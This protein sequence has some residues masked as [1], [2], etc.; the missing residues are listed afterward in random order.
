MG[1]VDM[2]RQRPNVFRMRLLGAEVVPV[3][4]GSKTLKDAVNETLRDWTGSVR[5]TH[6]VLG[7]ALGP[8]PFPTIVRDFQS[9]MGTEARRQIRR[10]TG[11]LPTEVV[12]CV[13]GGSNAIG[14][15]T[16]FV[17][18]REVKLVG[19][20]AG[21]KGLRGAQHA[22]RLTPTKQSRQG[23][24]QGYYSY[25]LQDAYG[26]IANT[27]SVSA[28]LDYSG[29]GPEHAWLRET[30][31]A[32][33]THATDAEAVKA[34]RVL[35]EVEGIIPA[36]ESSH[37]VAYALKRAPRLSEDDILL[38]NLSGRGDKDIFHVA[39]YLGMEI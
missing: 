16:P 5:T 11:R 32:H 33:Y 2:A 7:S 12:A 27:H 8:H 19:V 24:L 17:D 30:G 22:V 4:S 10:L 23:I 21:G 31:R 18:D 36:L 35:S 20:E 25:I 9:V 28:G 37:A 39:D 26:Q 6:Y 1:S 3:E 34:F 38:V 15:F 14:I 13:G 29:V